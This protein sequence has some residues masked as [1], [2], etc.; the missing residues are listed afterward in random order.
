MAEYHD[1][2][3]NNMSRMGNDISINTQRNQMNNKHSNYM[4]NNLYNQTCNINN[5]L[6]K[7][8]S[9][10]NIF[11]KGSQQVGPEGCNVD[12]LTDL[13]TG[14]AHECTKD[15]TMLQ[16]RTF[17]TVPYLGRGNCNVIMEQ[18]I[19]MGDASKEKKSDNQLNEQPCFDINNYPLE[20]KLKQQASDPKYKIESDAAEGWV[21]GGMCTRDFYRAS[22]YSM[23]GNDKKRESLW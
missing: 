14:K 9:Q 2:Y 23:E 10:P 11:F 20:H 4:V 5:D 12:A 17:L 16:Q 6:L 19:R 1:Y 7:A 18:Q 13:L 22:S 3:F 15:R 8:T 21:R